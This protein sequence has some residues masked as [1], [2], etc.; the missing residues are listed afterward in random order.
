M[1]VGT[2]RSLAKTDEV[3]SYLQLEN[4]DALRMVDLEA[5]RTRARTLGRTVD[6]ETS[7]QA[8]RDAP[9]ALEER[10]YEGNLL[11]P[12]DAWNKMLTQLGNLHEAGQQLAEAR[13]RAAR[14]E[15]EV[16]F[17]RERLK[18]LR[19]ETTS[20]GPSPESTA[21]SSQPTAPSPQPR[22]S[23]FSYIYRGWRSRR[24]SRP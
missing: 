20:P 19:E 12:I 6:D 17:L 13:E 11:V 15:T 23:F 14:A 8:S 2:V 18:E 10:A 16:V 24:P 4:G 22:S 9:V 3:P 5:V 1:P 7:E 21:P